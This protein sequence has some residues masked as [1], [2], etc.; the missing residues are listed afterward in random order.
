MIG[1]MLTALSHSTAMFK[2]CVQA[3]SPAPKKRPNKQ[4]PLPDFSQH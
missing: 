2:I 4:K 3:K 1:Y